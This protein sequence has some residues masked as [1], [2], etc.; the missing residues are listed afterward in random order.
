MNHRDRLVGV[1]ERTP[2]DQ[3]PWVPD[4]GYW[5]E[6]ESKRGRLPKEY[7]GGKGRL[8]LCKDLNVCAY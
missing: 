1:L 6:A 2:I 5:M 7:Q 4:L 8:Q 3:L